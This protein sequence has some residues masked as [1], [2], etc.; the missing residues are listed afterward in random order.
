MIKDGK[1]IINHAYQDI[2]YDDY[3]QTFI[4]KRGSNTG[5]SDINGKEIIPLEYERNQCK[6]NL[7]TS[8]CL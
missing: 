5:V 1:E 7:Y 8:D 2:E 6:R 3:N 4:L